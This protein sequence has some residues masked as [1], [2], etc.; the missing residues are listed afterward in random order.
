MDDVLFN[1]FLDI[2]NETLASAIAIVAVSLLLY[3][4]SRNTQDRVARASAVVLGAVTMTYICDALLSLDPA[5]NAIVPLLRA[6]WLGIALAPAALVHLSDALLSTTGLPSRG[7]RRRAYRLMY[8]LAAIFM[9]LAAASDSLVAPTLSD[10]RPA[11]RA[12]PLMGLYIVYLVLACS[13]ALINVERARRRCL[14]RSTRRRML[15]LEI[16]LLTPVVGV[17]PFSTFFALGGEFT[18]GAMVL[19]IV[20]NVFVVLMLM[21]LA[22]PLSF[23]GSVLPDRAVKSELLRFMLRGPVTGFLIVGVIFSTR[24]ATRIL[25]V[26]GE[27]FTVFATVAVVLFWLWMVELVLPR[28]DRM[29]IYGDDE[30]QYSRIQQLARQ[31]LTRND[32]INLL[33]GIL[34]QA[35]NILQTP[36]AFVALLTDGTVEVVRATGDGHTVE[37]RPGDL[38]A[39]VPA[40]KAA[41]VGKPHVWEGFWLFPLSGQRGVVN[42]AGV[43]VIGALGIKAPSSDAT[44][45]A[46]EL[47][48]LAKVRRRA[49]RTLDDLLLQGELSAALEG[50]LPQFT[51]SRRSAA[52]FE[53][54][55]G[56][57][58]LPVPD[59]DQPSAPAIDYSLIPGLPDREHVVEQVQAALRHYY[60][61]PGLT[62]SRLLE[63]AV[64]REAL[65][66]HAN[67]PVRA[68][69][70]VLDRAIETLRPPGERDWRSQEWLI[71]NVI[72]LRY[73]KKLRVRDAANR[74]YMADATL[75]RKQNVAIESVADALMRMEIDALMR[76]GSE[77]TN[78]HG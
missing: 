6:Q 62:Q 61:G 35:R 54:E 50:L 55:P 58:A 20:G 34:A 47:A 49:A 40:L 45:S 38:L 41:S 72:E 26:S 10:G 60:G 64:V 29:L 15:Y 36:G 11:L 48:V 56:R 53:Y 18:T 19:L 7:R 13:F 28:L 21:F 51:Q 71:Y 2:L 75:Y 33:E 74:L 3:N 78:A 68:L 77:E 46:E 27:E 22:Y 12:A 76:A 66:D 25:G 30:D 5:T 32:L 9:L 59:G 63:L 23:F 42:G 57:V 67:Q 44:P 69:R 14:T 31:L 70:T 73:L 8:V 4:L 65:P 39:E 43:Q 1:A 17:F 37:Q 52:E 24:S 16:A